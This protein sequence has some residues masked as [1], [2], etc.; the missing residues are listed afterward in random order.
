MSGTRIRSLRH[1][2]LIALGGSALALLAN[3]A[4]GLL[5]GVAGASTSP[6]ALTLQWQD[7]GTPDHQWW[8]TPAS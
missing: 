1:G 2:R 5:L 6:G 3:A 7:N 4:S 8:I